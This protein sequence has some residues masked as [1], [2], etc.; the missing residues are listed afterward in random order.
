[1]NQKEL[2]LRQRRWLEFIKDYELVMDYHPGKA[3][4]IADA[5]SRKSLFAL[6]AMITQLTVTDDGLILAEM[7]AKSMF[8]QEICEAQKGDKDLQAKIGQ[9]EMG[10][11][12]EFRI[13]IDGRIM[14]RDR[15]CVPKD[16]ELVQKILREAHSCCLSI[17]SGS[18]KMVSEGSCFRCGS[19]DHFIKDCPEMMEKERFQ[20]SRSSDAASRERPS[21][22]A[23]NGSGS[24]NVTQ[25]TAVRSEARASARAY[26]ICTREDATSL[27]VVTGNF[28]LY[29]TNVITLIDLGSTYSYVC[30]K[31][32]SRFYYT[33]L[34]AL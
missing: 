1:M 18:V 31:L 6:R 30:M 3:N 23:R 19:L 22:N 33:D 29:D 4:V 9:C 8:L 28:S 12:S 10:N 14:Y 27:D 20:S 15:I 26:A 5:L 25:D 11:E 32:A 16:D 13:G 7:K 2:N 21:K 17:H 34:P 24:K